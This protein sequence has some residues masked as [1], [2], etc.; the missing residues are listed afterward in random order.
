[1]DYHDLFIYDPSSPTSLTWAIDK[2]RKT[3]IGDK[4]GSKA[5]NGFYVQITDDYGVKT[6]VAVARIIW[7]LFNGPIPEGRVIHFLNDDKYDASIENL[8][9]VD[10]TVLNYIN[11]T[12]R[13]GIHIRTMANGK[14]RGVYKKHNKKISLGHFDTKEQL[15]EAY[16][17]TLNKE[18]TNA[19][20]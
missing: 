4:A 2:S 5:K 14:V 18:L 9:C 12:K 1:M 15:L 20:L 7:Q 11:K 6:S 17:T 10:R 13:G 3:R 16:Y 19:G 8:A